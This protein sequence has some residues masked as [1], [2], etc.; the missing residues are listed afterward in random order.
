M[1]IY[2]FDLIG[3]SFC[4]SSNERVYITAVG[5][6]IGFGDTGGLQAARAGGL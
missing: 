4:T 5:C 2:G 6:E 3:P 1:R